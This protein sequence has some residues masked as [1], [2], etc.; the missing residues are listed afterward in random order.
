MKLKVCGLRDQENI[1]QVLNYQPDYIGFIF[2]EK[3]PRY[4]GK[5]L[6]ADFTQRISSV[7]KVGVFV[8]ESEINILDHVSRFGLDYVQ[9]H[10]NETPVFCSQIQKNVPV[11]KAFGIGESFDFSS[12]DVYKDAC[13]YFLFDSSSKGYGGSGKT[14]NW[15]KLKEYRINKPFF[16]SGGIELSSIEE[17][18]NLKAQISNL[19]AVDVNSRFETAPGIKDISKIKELQLKTK[20]HVI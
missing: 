3:S 8:N 7:K 4:A 15:S 2:Y 18:L 13:T 1:M 6:Q 14:F 9:L 12:L 16:L 11:I 10:G 17:I 20:A 5:I 19:Y